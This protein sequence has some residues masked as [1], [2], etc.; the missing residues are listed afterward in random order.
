MKKL[1][2]QFPIGT[3]V[4][5]HSKSVFGSLESSNVWKRAQAKNQNYL[6]VNGYH[7]DRLLLIETVKNTSGG[8]YY[9]STDVTLY[10]QEPNYNIF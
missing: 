4:V 1:E 7:A 6:Y 8:D 10:N 5:P 3:M 2:K 9:L